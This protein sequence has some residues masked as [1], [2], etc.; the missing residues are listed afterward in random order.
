[1]AMALNGAAA[2]EDMGEA[3]ATTDDAAVAEERADVVGA[4]VRRDVEVLRSTAEEQIADASAD[5]IGLVAAALE[6]A[7]DLRGVGVDGVLFEGR[8]VTDEAGRRMPLE[9]GRNLFRL[10]LDSERGEV[11][12][13][14]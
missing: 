11:R 14:R 9:D 7:D 12:R 10:R 8:V 3:E 1:M 4:R 13:R 6:T 5:E 2:E